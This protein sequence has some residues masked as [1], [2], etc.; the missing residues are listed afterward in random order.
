[1]RIIFYLYVR[2]KP[3]EKNFGNKS[4]CSNCKKASCCDSIDSPP[5]FASDLKKLIKIK[6]ANGRYLQTVTIGG[7]TLFTTIK[8]KKNSSECIFFNRK[9]KSC[10]IYNDRPFDCQIYPFDVTFIDGEPWWIV[11]SCN[12]ISNWKWTEDHLKKIE[13]YPQFR[14]MVEKLDEYHHYV[15]NALDDRSM[16]EIPIR[17]V[18]FDNL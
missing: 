4:L 5:V 13:R 8:K 6:K 17:K 1:M 10:K 2:Q 16:Q 9:N 18:N 15:E 14:E 11:Y 12:P 7:R 3:D